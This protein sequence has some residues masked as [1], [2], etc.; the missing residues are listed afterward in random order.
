MNKKNTNKSRKNLILDGPIVKTLVSLAMPIIFAMV[1][2]MIYNLTDTFWV[3]RLG[4]NAVASV[5]LSW[6]ILFLITSFGNGLGIAGTI[7][8]SQYKG[9]KDHRN[10]DFIS[11]QTISAMF[12]ISAVVGVFGF[13]ISGPLIGLMGASP[14]VIPDAVKY[15]KISFLGVLFS[16]IY[17]SFQSLM[18]GIG[19]VKIPLYIVLCSVLLNLVLDPLFIMGWNFIPSFGVAGAAWTTI[20]SQALSSLVGIIILI[21][22]SR[23]IK[24]H[25]K[26]LIPHV[27][28]FKKMFK[29]GT[30]AGISQSVRALN[31]VLITFLVV[32]FGTISVAAFGLG[33]RILGLI[34]V[35]GMGFSIAISTMVGQN[36]GAKKIDRAAHVSNRGMLLAFVTLTL[37][38]IIMFIAAKSVASVFVPGEIE[39][40][41]QSAYF[42]RAMALTFGF[43][44]LNMAIIGVFNG[45]GNTHNGMFLSVLSLVFLFCF[46]FGL[47][48]FTSLGINGV[49]IAYPISNILTGL[50]SFIWIKRSR[51]KEIKII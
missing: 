4:A 49:W 12:L 21:K 9:K 17:F 46:G 44:G 50:I 47:S 38:G 40:I 10:V 11:A 34:I 22:G 43:I 42:I 51:W 31:M 27:G 35:P 8:V 13:L 45:S 33:V 20:I 30:P 16:Y 32:G 7:L 39:V 19:E 23:G 15:L 36:M 2:Q 1:L 3:G 48:R 37:F 18:N 41:R 14:S 6:P 28:I 25:F 5:S 29:L 24:M 26:D